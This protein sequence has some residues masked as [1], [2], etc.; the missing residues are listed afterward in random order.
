MRKFLHNSALAAC[1]IL[2]TVVLN[3]DVAA[4]AKKATAVSSTKTERM[5]KE[6]K[7]NYTP[8]Q[9]KRAYIVTFKGTAKS[10]INVILVEV[11]NAVAMV[12]DVAAVNEVDLTPE[13]LKELLEYN[14]R[15]D[16]IKVGISDQGTVQVQTEQGLALL[17]GKVFSQM[18]DQVAAGADEVAKILAPVRKGSAPAK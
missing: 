17:T 15:V 1:S 11:E 10:D 13:V 16:Y 4:Q 5:L 7:A 6:I 3:G 2:L 18:L 8:T 14:A 12:A 9:D